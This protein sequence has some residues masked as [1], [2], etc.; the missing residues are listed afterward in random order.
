LT[1]IAGVGTTPPKTVALGGG[2]GKNHIGALAQ[3][4]G[5]SRCSARATPVWPTGPLSG[6]MGTWPVAGSRRQD[7]R[8]AAVGH[9]NDA[10]RLSAAPRRGCHQ[11]RCATSAQLGCT[12]A[13]ALALLWCRGGALRVYGAQNQRC[14][15]PAD[16]AGPR[17]PSDRLQQLTAPAESCPVP[18]P[19]S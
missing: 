12:M 1:H 10:G 9:V 3:K 17:H 2:P 7:G 11:G 4:Q 19:S 18:F 5:Y 13:S 15:A 8:V 6:G 14:V 16:L